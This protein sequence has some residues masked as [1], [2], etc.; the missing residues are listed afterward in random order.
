MDG[1]I[2]AAQK[3]VECLATVGPGLNHRTGAM[4][5]FAR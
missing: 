1:G 2:H 4:T 5:A 3:V